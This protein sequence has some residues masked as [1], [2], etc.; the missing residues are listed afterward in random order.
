MLKYA[1]RANVSNVV[2]DKLA[3]VEFFNHELKEF[4]VCMK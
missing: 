2:L 3:K 1:R 4:V